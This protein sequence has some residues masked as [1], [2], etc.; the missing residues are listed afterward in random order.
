[1]TLVESLFLGIVANT[2]LTVLGIVG[3]YKG[4][5]VAGCLA[6]LALISLA[7]DSRSLLILLKR[8][9]SGESLFDPWS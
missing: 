1:M 9:K 2:G 7:L 6:T 3:M 4:Y 8:S 5:E